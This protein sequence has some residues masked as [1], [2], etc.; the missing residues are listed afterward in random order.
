MF[1]SDFEKNVHVVKCDSSLIAADLYL[2][3]SQVLRMYRDDINCRVHVLDKKNE[4]LKMNKKNVPLT[5]VVLFKLI[6][7]FVA[8]AIIWY[9][10][11]M[12]VYAEVIIILMRLNGSF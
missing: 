9:Y 4:D 12:L 2:L 1:A 8:M 7:V 5:P 3:F 6:F 10:A 11:Q